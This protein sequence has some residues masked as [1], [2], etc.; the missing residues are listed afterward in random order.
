MSS[1]LKTLESA[2]DT[3]RIS[4]AL[5]LFGVSLYYRGPTKTR[6]ECRYLL[7]V[8]ALSGGDARALLNLI[9][10][11]HNGSGTQISSSSPDIS[12]IDLEL[13][14]LAEKCSIS[15]RDGILSLSL[16]QMRLSVIELSIS[17]L[18]RPKAHSIERSQ[19][20]LRSMFLYLQGRNFS[21]RQWCDENAVGQFAAQ[22]LLA[23][24]FACSFDCGLE[25]MIRQ[26]KE[27]PVLALQVQA[28]MDDQ[29]FTEH[30]E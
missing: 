2:I 6:A 27:A 29:S 14:L 1:T 4:I 7:D 9:S 3:D 25:W 11:R 15:E 5:N 12:Q 8:I 20:F 21:F 10:G 23:Q 13:S 28:H 17:K 18:R 24:V 26:M 19:T 16:D 30:H 22:N